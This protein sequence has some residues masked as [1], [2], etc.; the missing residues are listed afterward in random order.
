MPSPVH[1][2]RHRAG[3]ITRE[4]MTETTNIAAPADTLSPRQRFNRLAVAAVVATLPA[5]SLS[6]AESEIGIALTMFTTAAVVTVALTID[7]SSLDP[8]RATAATVILYLV[9]AA[10]AIISFVFHISGAGAILTF[11]MVASAAVVISVGSYSIKDVQRYVAV[12]LLA[13]TTIQAAFVGLQTAT[14]TA[15][16]YSL[17]HP[18]S[19]L[20]VTNETIVR[21]QGL[22][23]HVYEAA[24][25]ALIA[26]A[27]GMALLPGA[28][29][30]RT[31]FLVA[32]GAATTTIALT[33]SRSALLGLILV[34]GVAA[35]ASVRGD[36]AIRAGLVVVTVAFVIPA[37]M[38]ASAWQVRFDESTESDLDDASLGR[39]TLARQ[40]IE[41]A[42]DHPIIGVGPNRY[43]AVLEAEYT[44]DE[45]YPWVVHNQSL[46]VA[47]ELGI[48]AAIAITLVFVLAGVQAIRAGYRPLLL[49]V[50]PLPFVIFDV[51]LYNRPVGLLLFAV[52]CGASGSL[53]MKRNR[54][55]AGTQT[56]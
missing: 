2:T 41:M 52:W 12:P 37:L 21:P 32:I 30:I 10:V 34:V 22:Y 15:I 19:S 5:W 33:H 46:M 18:G 13:M 4:P 11:T 50:A 39:V 6:F 9:T 7:R 55:T 27:V 17:L 31:A 48:P 14:E 1:S 40:A 47:A 29:R 16:G 36:K 49:Y 44:V 53:W 35:L 26:V 42:S 54:Q 20:L 25:V 23:H 56:A 38:T 43:M 28:G 45:E 24:A 8:V 51:L 3:T